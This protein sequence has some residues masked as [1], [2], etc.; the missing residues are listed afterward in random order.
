MTAKLNKPQMY[1][2]EFYFQ[3]GATKTSEL[4]NLVEFFQNHIIPELQTENGEGVDFTNW[5]NSEFFT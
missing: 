5:Y 4:V 3:H 2:C 1:R